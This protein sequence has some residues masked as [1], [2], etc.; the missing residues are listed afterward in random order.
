MKPYRSSH[1]QINQEQERAITLKLYQ[2]QD[3]IRWTHRIKIPAATL[4]LIDS[5][6]FW[7]RWDA[8]T[9][10]ISISKK[11]VFEHPWF[12]VLSVLR[13]EMAHQYASEF[14]GSK[15]NH[16]DVFRKCC[17][18]LGVPDYFSGASA[19]LQEHSLDWKSKSKDESQE[20][21][22]NKVEKL[23]ALATSSNEHEALLAMEKVRELYARHNLEKQKSSRLSNERQ[24]MHHAIICHR[25]KRIEPHQTKICGILT[26]HFFVNVL[27]SKEFDALSGEQFQAIELIGTRENVLMA[28]YVYYFLLNQTEFFLRERKKKVR[29]NPIMPHSMT[30]HEAKSFRFGI[31]EGFQNKLMQAERSPV[32]EPSSV[33]SAT[34]D[35]SLT[36]ALITLKNDTSVDDYIQAVYPRLRT[37]TSRGP[38]LDSEAY[39]AGHEEGTRLTLHK[40]VTSKTGNSGRFLT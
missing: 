17:I 4:V 13:H 3:T 7:G 38:S 35:L 20:K 11:L 30:R 31:L 18:K 40:G 2:E 6:K 34:S 36:Q 28:E 8:E 15:H 10:T 22:L 23:L 26:G 14:Y 32:Y 39:F 16:D 29:K 24:E 5:E 37:R 1:A 33:P 27:F 25:K 19:N 9:R 12:S 21:L